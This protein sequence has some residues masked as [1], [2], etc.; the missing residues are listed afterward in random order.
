MRERIDRCG[1]LPELGE[2][3]GGCL[4]WVADGSRV[5]WWWWQAGHTQGWAHGAR[6][7]PGDVPSRARAGETVGR[8]S[9]Y[10]WTLTPHLGDSLQGGRE[11]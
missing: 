7:A 6:G 5:R 8:S 4:A 9:A 10:H 3:R 1:D 11:M 2:A